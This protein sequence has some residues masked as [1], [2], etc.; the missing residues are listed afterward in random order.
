MAHRP[1]RVVILGFPPAQML[2]IAG[3]LEVLSLANAVARSEGAPVPYSISLGAPTA[4]PLATT[5]GV[6]LVASLSLF[7]T[8]VKAD[9]LLLSGGAGARACVSDARLVAALTALCKR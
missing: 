7:D 2:D 3:P 6:P 4:G 9:T 5:S 8:K 1:H